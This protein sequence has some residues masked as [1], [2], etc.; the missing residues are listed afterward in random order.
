MLNADARFGGQ[1]ESDHDLIGS[2]VEPAARDHVLLKAGDAL[3][4]LRVAARDRHAELLCAM[5]EER[6]STNGGC[7]RL[8]AGKC[9][10]LPGNQGHVIEARPTLGC[11]LHA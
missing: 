7:N 11:R 6:L 10:K 2:Q 8:H 4:K 3:L 1:S 5:N 9:R